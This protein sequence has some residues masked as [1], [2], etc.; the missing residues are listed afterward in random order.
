[1][2]KGR[3]LEEA[4]PEL[5]EGTRFFVLGLAPNAARIAV[6]FWHEDT[7]GNLAAASASITE[8]SRSSPRHGAA[9]CPPSGGCSTKP[10]SSARPRTS[11]PS[12]RRGHARDP[13]R[14]P[15]SARAAR[16]GDH[17]HARR[18]R[19]INGL[20]AAICKACLNRDSRLSGRKEDIP[21]SLDKAEPESR[22]PARAAVRRAGERRSAPRSATSTRPSATAT[23]APR[24]PPRPPC[25]RCCCATATITCADCARKPR[26]RAE[27]AANWYEQRDRPRSSTALEQS[28]H[29]TCAS[30]I[31]A[32]SPSATTT[33]ARITAR[34]P[35]APEESTAADAAT[36]TPEDRGMTHERD[37]E[38]L[39]IRLSVRRHQRQS[40][41][42]IPTPATCPPRP[43]D[44]SRAWSPTSASS[45]R[46][47]TTCRWPRATSSASTS[48]SRSAPSSTNGTRAPRTRKASSLTRRATTA[49]CPRIRPR[50]AS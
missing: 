12:R 13:H 32:A 11:R 44:Q 19:A 47:A 22:L 31:R 5:R 7:L 16:R 1:M 40:R 15:L 14:Q 42:A 29:A 23:T 48:T 45:A 39:R 28:S 43:R 8:T 30:R 2:T 33:S 25:F 3:P 50:R 34:R 17:A 36:D 10:P 20:R 35:E 49:S 26:V 46:S 6:R 38:P 37:P 9:R 21:V 4:A 18:R 27:L 41:T 24:R